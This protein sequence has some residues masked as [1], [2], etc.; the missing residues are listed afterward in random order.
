[1]TN[2][3]K[4]VE[5]IDCC[6]GFAIVL[7]VIGHII[8]GYTGANFFDEYSDIMIRVFN[9]IYS[10][11]MPLFFVV[12]GFVFYL[13]YCKNIEKSEKRVHLQ[14]G[15]MIWIYF[16]MSIV[17]WIFKMIFVSSVNKPY[18]LKN[19]LLIPIKP[20]AVYW[21]IYILVFYYLIFFKIEKMKI[22]RKYVLSAVTII[23]ILG[24]FI[25]VETDL[26]FPIKNL[27]QNMIFFY[28]GIL[29]SSFDFGKSFFEGK[30]KKL[31]LAFAG[32]VTIGILIY[33]AATMYILTGIGFVGIVLPLIVSLTLISLFCFVDA[34][35][36]LLS[37]IGTYS[38][39]IYLTHIF[40][41]SANRK[42]LIALGITNF[43]LNF[44]T[45]LMMSVFIPIG[46]AYILK[47]MKLHDLIFRPFTF[48]SKRKKNLQ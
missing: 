45:N 4:R 44:V 20:I 39:E 41:T 6:K 30:K 10:F 34:K 17:L 14:I 38:L 7:V 48:F 15:N 13:A 5:W 19:L 1:M 43:Y 26:I 3:G 46:C 16:L 2:N 33:S 29:L 23:S 36:K 25:P 31:M 24:S 9:C 35:S 18:T 27:L 47:K 28:A 22:S 12:S 40:I 37:L 42:I 32:I 11:H 21:Y 8:D